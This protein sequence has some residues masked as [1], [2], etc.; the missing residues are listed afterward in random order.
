[1]EIT[2]RDRDVDLTRLVGQQIRITKPSGVWTGRLEDARINNS[3][4]DGPFWNLRLETEGGS[5]SFTALPSDG[6]W[7]ITVP[8][9][10]CPDCGAADGEPCSYACSSRLAEQAGGPPA[11]TGARP[12]DPPTPCK[13]VEGGTTR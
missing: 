9:G 2:H 13:P 12:V 6:P 8:D 10:P 5:T 11:P 7:T 4:L 1:M 3:R